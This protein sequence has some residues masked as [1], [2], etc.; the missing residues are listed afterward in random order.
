MITRI[1]LILFLLT[2]LSLETTIA[3]SGYEQRRAEIR[4]Q[5][6]NTRSEIE[7][8]EEQI[9]TY[10]SRLQLASQRF[11]E[12]YQQYEELTRLITLQDERIRRMEQEQRQIVRRMQ[13]AVAQIDNWG[14]TL[15]DIG[16][17]LIDFPSRREGRLVYLCW[18]PDDLTLCVLPKAR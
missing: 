2:A 5:Q 3:Q 7:L 9:E 16:T 4:E 8:L 12:M 1:A 18:R 10:Q 6:Q 17:G 14:I 15:R 13:Y 11:D